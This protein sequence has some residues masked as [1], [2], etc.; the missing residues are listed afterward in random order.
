MVPNYGVML[1]AKLW[2]YVERQGM[3]PNYGAILS[4]KLWCHALSGCDSNST[5]CQCGKITAWNTWD[6]VPE[7]TETFHIILHDPTLLTK[8]SVH[9]QRLERYFVIQFSKS[10]GCSR[11]N[12]ARVTIFKTSTRLLGRLPP[13]QDALLQHI[14][15]ALLQAGYIWKQA[16][17][18]NPILPPFT[19]WGWKRNTAGLLVPL[20]SLLADASQACSLL[21]HCN[22]KV[23]CTGNC[24][25]TEAG[26]TCTSLCRCDG[27]CSNNE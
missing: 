15:R 17:K 4:V 6:L 8:D 11:V 10:S 23:S 26:L 12:E 25:C 21:I 16:L 14:K 18:P 5:P 1:S 3:V 20:W 7:L 24:K 22:C 2:G 19:D 27:S 13:T 9:M